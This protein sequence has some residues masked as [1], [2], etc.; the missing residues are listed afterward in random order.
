MIF[1]VAAI[2]DFVSFT[3]VTLE[4]KVSVYDVK[5]WELVSWVSRA[6]D[7]LKKFWNYERLNLHNEILLKILE[8]QEN[9]RH[10]SIQKKTGSG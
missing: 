8:Y 10:N 2:S 6:E 5:C 4:A 1:Q 7:E 9:R 3:S